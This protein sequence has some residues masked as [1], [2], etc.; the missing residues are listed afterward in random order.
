MDVSRHLLADD[1][2]HLLTTHDSPGL[3]EL[4][5]GFHAD[6]GHDHE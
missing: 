3:D 1:G 6:Y 5:G 2:S 4:P